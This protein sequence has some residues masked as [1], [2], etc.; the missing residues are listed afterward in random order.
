MY[1][2]GNSL[3]EHIF[4][5]CWTAR[6]R[7]PLWCLAIGQNLIRTGFFRIILL[8]N[9]NDMSPSLQEFSCSALRINDLCPGASATPCWRTSR[10]WSTSTSSQGRKTPHQPAMPRQQCGLILYTKLNYEF[11]FPGI[12]FVWNT[13]SHISPCFFFQEVLEHC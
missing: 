11:L 6:V 13:F 2:H 7:F 10:T 12:L 1:S 4:L 8:L 9:D 3:I 5:Y